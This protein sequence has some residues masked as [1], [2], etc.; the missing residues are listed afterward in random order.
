MR[1]DEDMELMYKQMVN[2][3]DQFEHVWEMLEKIWTER[4]QEIMSGPERD[5]DIWV[6][7]MKNGRVPFFNYRAAYGGLLSWTP[8]EFVEYF[9]KLGIYSGEQVN[10]NKMRAVHCLMWAHGKTIKRS[11]AHEWDAAINW[12]HDPKRDY[13]RY[14]D[15][16][17]EKEESDR[18]RAL[19]RW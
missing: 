3:Y 4:N 18:R 16:A 13:I 5:R 11:A 8:P 15:G 6:M 19:E 17:K 12:S 1:C 14:F 9:K 2:D 7:L 10:A